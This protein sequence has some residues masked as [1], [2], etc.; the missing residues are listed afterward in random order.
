MDEPGGVTI[1]RGKHHEPAE[2]AGRQRYP[3]LRREGAMQTQ[4]EAHHEQNRRDQVR[5]YD[6][7]REPEPQHPGE[8]ATNDVTATHADRSA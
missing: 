6:V 8:E 5:E 4:V 2:R 1:E 7:V 3:R